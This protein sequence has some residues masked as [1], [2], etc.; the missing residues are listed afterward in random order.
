MPPCPLWFIILETIE[1]PEEKLKSKFGSWQWEESVI[2]HR[3]EVSRKEVV[4]M[5]NKKGF[6]LIELLVVLAIIAILMAI[7]VPNVITYIKRGNMVKAH[8]EIRSMELALTKMLTDTG[9]SSFSQ[10][11]NGYR[12]PG[13]ED[14]DALFDEL[15][16]I[17]KI[18]TDSFYILLRQGKNA[19]TSANFLLGRIPKEVKAK[20]SDSYLDVG[21][22]PWGNKYRF[23]MGPWKSGPMYLRSYREAFQTYEGAIYIY[24]DIAKGIEDDEIPG[25]PR[26]DYK[27]GYPA[28]RNETIY[29]YS[30]GENM[31]AD[32]L[33]GDYEKGG[34]VQQD[35]EYV[36]GGDDISSWDSAAGWTKFYN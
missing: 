35:L 13:D 5:K 21:K 14:E 26:A 28:P 33:Y 23:I 25:N 17:E 20:L 11:F 31:Q 10:V 3:A 36:G 1:K 19:D 24:N 29:I 34:Y 15:L 16:Y 30:T 22:D 27:S 32:H 12:F 2:A 9:R 6:T 7:T 4:T 8:A 18:Y